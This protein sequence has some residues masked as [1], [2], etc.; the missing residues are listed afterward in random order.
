MAAAPI[1]MFTRN[2]WN[3]MMASMAVEMKTRLR[4]D[5]KSAM[6]GGR[7]DEMKLI[8]TLITAIDH[9]EAVPVAQQGFSAQ[10]EFNSGSAEA[11]RLELNA[12]EVRGLI[13][14]EIEE[15]EAAAAEFE[16]L[17]MDGKAEG[18]RADALLARRYVAAEELS[19][20]DKAP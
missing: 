15:R 4:E 7:S 12:S 11:E 16:R 9:A 20:S 3:E 10:R 8:R 13:L 6:K 19:P 18:L 5:L 1:D 14:K 2:N 17:G